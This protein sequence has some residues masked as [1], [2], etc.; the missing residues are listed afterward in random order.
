MCHLS[1]MAL[2]MPTLRILL[3]SA[4]EKG[5]EIRH[6]GSEGWA[7]WGMASVMVRLP[8]CMEGRQSWG[9]ASRGRGEKKEPM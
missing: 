8:V 1:W 4:D 5:Q 9:Q 6:A 2:E 3:T 7:T